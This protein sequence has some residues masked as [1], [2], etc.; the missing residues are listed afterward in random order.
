M[1]PLF[2][3]SI[4]LTYNIFFSPKTWQSRK[5]PWNWSPFSRTSKMFQVVWFSLY[6]INTQINI[7]RIETWNT[8]VLGKTFYVNML[9]FSYLTVFA[10]ETKTVLVLLTKNL[11]M[12]CTPL[13][14]SDFLFLH[15]SL[16]TNIFSV[17]LHTSHIY[18]GMRKKA[19]QD[20][21]RSFKEHSTINLFSSRS[22]TNNSCPRHTTH[23]EKIFM[24]M[25][26]LDILRYYT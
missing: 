14:A 5:L 18:V 23:L 17:V 15:S 26:L 25:K 22:L 2:V 9:Y 19:H 16:S 6:L 4:P 13:N 11:F 10:Y 8:L 3:I 7:L 24:K 20:A 21:L 1:Y 12:P